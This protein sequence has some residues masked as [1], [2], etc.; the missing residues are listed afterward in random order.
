MIDVGNKIL[1]L[2]EHSVFISKTLVFCFLEKY[3][4]HFE[5]ILQWQCITFGVLLVAYIDLL[6]YYETKF[7]FL[8]FSTRN[9]CKNNP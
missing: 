7:E 5:L 3:N 1:M 8:S 6:V 2:D 4:G 9:T